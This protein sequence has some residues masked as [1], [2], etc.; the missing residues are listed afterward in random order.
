MAMADAI[1]TIFL[2]SAQIRCMEEWKDWRGA[3]AA[4]LVWKQFQSPTNRTRA[5]EYLLGLMPID[6]L[7][8]IS[9]I[10]SAVVQPCSRAP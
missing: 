3:N 5:A 9:L 1:I 2:C 4:G 10:M 7:E 8:I 6:G